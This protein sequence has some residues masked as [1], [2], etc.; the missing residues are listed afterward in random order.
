MAHDQTLFVVIRRYGP[1]YDS[2]KALQHQLGWP[3]HA[4]FMDESEALG[5]TRLAGP[6]GTTGEV[7]LVVR[8]EAESAVTRHLAED[9]W[10]QSG[11]LTTVK[12]VPWDL[13]LGDV[14]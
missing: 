4:A 8:A 12:I 13:R 11:L 9:P 5:K 14:G 1:P 6:L 7:L 10:T 2:T 3:E